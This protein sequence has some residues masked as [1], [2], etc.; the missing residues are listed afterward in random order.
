MIFH[1]VIYLPTR[2]AFIMQVLFIPIVPLYSPGELKGINTLLPPCIR[3]Y[4]KRRFLSQG[5]FENKYG[6]NTD[7]CV[8]GD[9]SD[10]THAMRNIHVEQAHL[11]R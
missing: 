2:Q 9:G 7:Y 1:Q 3:K 5:D 4:M 10:A 8:H 11:S 6:A